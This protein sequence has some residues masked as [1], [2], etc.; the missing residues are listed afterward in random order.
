MIPMI[1]VQDAPERV[2]RV[3][4]SRRVLIVGGGASGVLLAAQ[5]L[6]RGDDAPVVTMIERREMLGCG[7]AYS[8]SNASHLL[9]TRV[10]SMSAFPDDP[11]HFLNWLTRNVGAADRFGFVDR[12][13]YGRY[14]A[15]LLAPWAGDAKLHCIKRDCVGIEQTRGGVVARLSDG[16]AVEADVAVLA[17][18]H[19]LPEPCP[20]GLVSQ[21]WSPG[22]P[23]PGPSQR[24]LIVGSRG[25]RDPGGGGRRGLEKPCGSIIPSVHGSNGRAVWSSNIHIC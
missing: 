5:L 12:G 6:A 9:N 17:T 1:D 16:A 21:P 2:A 13:T 23:V 20:D 25:R 11:D 15:D 3:G 7:V 22:G 4:K 14:M 19:V 18:G 8:T 10:S 24:V